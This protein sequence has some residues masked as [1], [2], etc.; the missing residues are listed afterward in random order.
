MKVFF[1][2]NPWSQA[3]KGKFILL[4]ASNHQEL[5]GEGIQI[6]SARNKTTAKWKK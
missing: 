6:L 4:T 5:V 2:K 3:S 1:N